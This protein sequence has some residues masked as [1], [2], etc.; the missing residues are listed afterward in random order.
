MPGT[1]KT[2]GAPEP[3]EVKRKN[4][5]NAAMPMGINLTNADLLSRDASARARFQPQRAQK[6]LLPML[7]ARP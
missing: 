1:I 2:K 7:K 4:A 3:A 5:M 6:G